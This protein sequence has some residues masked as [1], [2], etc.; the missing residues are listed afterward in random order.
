MRCHIALL[1]ATETRLKVSDEIGGCGAQGVTEGAKLHQIDPSL[2]SL[3]FTYVRLRFAEFLGQF[4][5]GQVRGKPSV[6]QQSTEDL[7]FARER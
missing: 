5:L 2:S 1:A 3:A 7:V 4:C 6:A